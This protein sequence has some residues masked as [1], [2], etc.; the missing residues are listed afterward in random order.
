[1]RQHV[2]HIFVLI[3]QCYGI[4]GL[5]MFFIYL[6]TLCFSIYCPDTGW[7]ATSDEKL[8]F[9]I[10]PEALSDLI[11]KVKL[12]VVASAHVVHIHQKSTCIIF[13]FLHS[14]HTDQLF[15]ISFT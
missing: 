4:Y 11:L 13:F 10:R 2:P 15:S 5:T 6:G 8:N 14:V 3:K 9:I 1:M 7:L 12:D